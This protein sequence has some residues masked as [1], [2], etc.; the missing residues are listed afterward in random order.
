MLEKKGEA[1]ASPFSFLVYLPCFSQ[2]DAAV[3]S[4]HLDLAAAFSYRSSRPA[5][6]ESALELNGIIAG[7][8]SVKR[9]ERH[10]RIET[11]WCLDRNVTVDSVEAHIAVPSQRG[12]P[13]IHAAVHRS[14]VNG[15]VASRD[16]D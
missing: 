13:H 6:T 1:D 14:R 8:G 12:H 11:R 10:S 9:A 4:L 7:Y 16:I 2:L 15:P 3:Y 5:R